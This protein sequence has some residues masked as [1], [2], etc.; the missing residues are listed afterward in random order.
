[1]YFEIITLNTSL[2]INISNDNIQ[3]N[4]KNSKIP[5]SSKQLMGDCGN[6]GGGNFTNLI[7]RGGANGK[8]LRTF[9]RIKDKLWLRVVTRGELRNSQKNAGWL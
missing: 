4:I 8:V 5:F 1:M 2:T 6:I 7:R 3:I 9:W